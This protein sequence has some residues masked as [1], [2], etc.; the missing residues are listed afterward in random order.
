MHLHAL[1][2]RRDFLSDAD[3]S[4][5]GDEEEDCEDKE[6]D[7]CDA[8]SGSCNASETKDCSNQCYDEKYDAPFKHKNSSLRLVMIA[9]R[10]GH[11][12]DA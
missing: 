11:D 12:C 2:V 3:A 7:F 10:T 8:D 6:E 4:D 9:A 5:E 1:D